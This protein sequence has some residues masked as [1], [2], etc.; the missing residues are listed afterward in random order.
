MPHEKYC[1]SASKSNMCSTC[2][3]QRPLGAACELVA[4][5]APF[6]GLG[7]IFVK[8]KLITCDQGN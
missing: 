3:P 4:M 6:W 1:R 7:P 8:S 5:F 2:A